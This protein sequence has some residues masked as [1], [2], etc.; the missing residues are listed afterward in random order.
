MQVRIKRRSSD[1][2]F[3]KL[4]DYYIQSLSLYPL[5]LF[6][7]LLL[8]YTVFYAQTYPPAVEVWSEPIRVDS[9]AVRF[10][11]E[12]SPSL[13]IDLSTLFL[14]ESSTVSV[15]NRI[16]TLWTLPKALNSNVNNGSPIRNPSISKDGRRLYY[17]R[18]GGY[19][20]WDLWYSELDTVLNDWG[21]SI[22]LGP[23]VNWWWGDYFAYELSFDTLYCINDLWASQGVCIF[24]NDSLTNEWQIVD[25]SNYN[26]PFGHGNI[27]GL[28][29]TANS[30]KAYFSRY[31]SLLSDS[32]QSELFVTYW[33]SVNNRWGEVYEL[34]I[35]SNAF[36]PDTNNN[37]NWIGG[38]DEYPWISPNGKILFFTSNRDAAR[39]DTST[40]PDIY[41]SYLLIDDNGNPVTVEKNLEIRESNEPI[42]FQNYP[43]PFNSETIIGFNL[44]MEETISL[45]IYDILGREVSRIIDK[46]VYSRGK[47]EV[48]VNFNN[49]PNQYSASGVYFYQLNFSNRSLTKK[50]LHIK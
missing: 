22:N 18:W 34:N 44:S 4:V 14:F 21:P 24:V 48:E 42:L 45:I 33:D 37:L 30:K 29:I 32:L 2:L 31:I 43:N 16:D 5:V 15:S 20:S 35:N 27:R 8:P 10:V 47:H 6:I 3:I 9:L 1:C 12:R 36:Q 7:I 38:R 11:G 49:N 41:V 17:S 50:L 40:A 23:N 26:H 25:S 13:T 28:S 19:G 39:E 46:K